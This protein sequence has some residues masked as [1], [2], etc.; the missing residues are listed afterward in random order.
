MR[1]KSSSK[2]SLATAPCDRHRIKCRTSIISRKPRL[3]PR[4]PHHYLH[5]TGRALRLREVKISDPALTQPGRGEPSTAA[6]AWVQSDLSSL[7]PTASTSP[8]P[9]PQ[10]SSTL[11]RPQATGQELHGHLVFRKPRGRSVAQTRQVPD[12]TWVMRDCLALSF[13]V[14]HLKCLADL[15]LPLTQPVP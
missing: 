12:T 13:S 1:H 15:L 11:P 6:Q 8:R 5:F 4:V 14:F 9:P 7:Y 3:N 10:Q 2:R